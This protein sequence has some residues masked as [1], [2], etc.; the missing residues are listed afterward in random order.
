LTVNIILDFWFAPKTAKH[1]YTYQTRIQ[2]KDFRKASLAQVRKKLSALHH[3][4]SAPAAPPLSRAGPE[5]PPKPTEIGYDHLVV[6]VPLNVHS[7]LPELYREQV[8]ENPKIHAVPPPGHKT[9][10]K[11]AENRERNCSTCTVC[12]HLKFLGAFKKYHQN[13]SACTVPL[14]ERGEHRYKG[15]CVCKQCQQTAEVESIPAPKRL[16]L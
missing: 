15:W 8:L 1:F 14:E 11:S 5:P 6:A 4:L 9:R 13:P 10:I 16:R 2:D 12:G 7:V 3:E